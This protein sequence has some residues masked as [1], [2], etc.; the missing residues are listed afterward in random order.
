MRADVRLIFTGN[1]IN[2]V[3][4]AL[5]DTIHLL[6][7]VGV[8]AKPDTVGK[9]G[10]VRLQQGGLAYLV[11]A[12]HAQ[13]VCR[14]LGTCAHRANMLEPAAAVY[15][16]Y[17][18]CFDGSRTSRRCRSDANILPD[19]SAA[20]RPSSSDIV[21]SHVPIFMEQL[22]MAIGRSPDRR[23]I[24]SA[25]GTISLLHRTERHEL[26]CPACW[27]RAGSHANSHPIRLPVAL[28]HPRRCD[29]GHQIER[30]T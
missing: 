15:L 1:K 9:E 18:G 12:C 26:Q 23:E 19:C 7:L 20:M 6:S 16:R 21:Y 29:D 11:T 28:L 14:L 4:I 2:G 3:L 10:V 5:R 30:H 22:P 27:R 8:T 25:R 13:L 24:H 17:S